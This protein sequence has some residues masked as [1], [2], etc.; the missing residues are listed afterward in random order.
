MKFVKNAL[1]SVGL[2]LLLQAGSQAAVISQW[3]Y[4]VSSIWTAATPVGAPP[5]GVALTASQLSWGETALAD[6]ST[7]T[8]T[9]PADGLVNTYIG[10]G[11]PPS[12]F[13]APGS[14]ITHANNPIGGVSLATATLLSSL[15]L[16]AVSPPGGPTGPAP[17]NL[18]ILFEETPNATPCAVTGSP[19]PCNDIFVLTTPLQNQLFTWD[20]DGAGG[21]APVDYYVN[22]F[23]TTGVLDLLEPAACIAAGIANG[24]CIGFTTPEN[25]T[26]ALPFSFTVSTEPSSVPEPGSMAL[27]GLALLGM[28]VARKRAA[29]V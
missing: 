25:L 15:T 20:S 9:N 13:A 27:A 21:D 16:N 11:L 22:I 19:T 6:R 26:T 23:P 10:S 24:I 2:G 12:I 8:I 5:A 28:T 3:S 1:V 29:K 14:T 18:N 7:L 4:N 17:I